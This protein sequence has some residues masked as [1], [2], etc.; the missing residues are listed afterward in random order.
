MKRY[1]LIGF[2]LVFSTGLLYLLLQHVDTGQFL[3]HFRSV[4]PMLLGLALT[5][6]LVQV[7]VA[8]RRWQLLLGFMRQD[9]SFGRTVM[10]FMIGLFFNQALPSTVGGDAA[11]SWYLVRA[12]CGVGVATINVLLD[13]IVAVAVLVGIVILTLP[14]MFSLVEDPGARAGTVILAV[15]VVAVLIALLQLFRLPKRFQHWRV[16][17]GFVTL[18]GYA[19]RLLREPATLWPVVALSAGVHLLSVFSVYVVAQSID[20]QVSLTAMLVIV[21]VMLF[22]SMVPV[23]IA[24]WGVREGVMV[25]ALGFLGVA[26]EPALVVSVLFGLMLLVVGLIGGGAWIT[27]RPPHGRLD[28]S[29]EEVIESR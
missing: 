11:R 15:A 8:A 9:W 4:N 1:L 21:P 14:L 24:G 23:S 3:E 6:L 18:S 10:V 27:H 7:A 5:S 25:V 13:R 20:L 28:D 19:R 2:K 12:G 22:V 16:V 26:P 17:S 29:I